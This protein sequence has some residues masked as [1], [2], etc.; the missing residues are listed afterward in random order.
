MGI[1]ICVRQRDDVPIVW[2]TVIYNKHSIVQYFFFY[3]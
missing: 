2:R 1:A 3:W